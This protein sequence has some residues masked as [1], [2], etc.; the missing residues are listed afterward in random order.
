MRHNVYGSHLSRTSEQRQSLFRSLIENLLLYK[1][2]QTTES[3][4]KAVKGLVDKVITQA[5]DKNYRAKI[6]TFI[7]SKQALIQLEDEVL[8]NLGDRRSGFL[9]IVRVGQRKGDGAMMVRMS[10]LLEQKSSP[11][12]KEKTIDDKIEDGTGSSVSKLKVTK[13]GTLKRSKNK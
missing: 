12:K 8:P 2:I 7:K 9:S 4:A 13:K 11:A 6:A 10:L 5:K 1:S 3:K